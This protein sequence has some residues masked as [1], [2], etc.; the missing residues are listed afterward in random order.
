MMPQANATAAIKTGSLPPQY[1]RRGQAESSAPFA[2]GEA[3][4]N[5]QQLAAGVD[6]P[7]R[8]SPT[9]GPGLRRLCQPT[10]ATVRIARVRTACTGRCR[11]CCRGSL[12]LRYQELAEAALR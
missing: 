9:S 1:R 8:E 2:T 10:R 4:I 5:T 7:L 6:A 3:D 11:G 12:A